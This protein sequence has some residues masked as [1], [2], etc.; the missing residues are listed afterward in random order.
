MNR[1][2]GVIKLFSVISLIVL[3]FIQVPVATAAGSLSALSDTMS[4]ISD[5]TPTSTLSN[6]T[7]KY[8][9]PTGVAAGQSMTVTFPTG[10][11]IG[12]VDYTDID[13]SWGASTGAET[14]L[15]LGA[16][17]ATSTWGAAFVGQILTVT[18]GTGTITAGSKVI[19]EIGTNA[20]AVAT[21]DQQIANHAT[22]ATY[23]LTIAGTFTD[24]GT[25]AIVLVTNDQVAVTASVDPSISFAISANTVALGAMTTGAV[26][27]ASPDITLTIGTNA[28]SGYVVTVQDQGN[29]TTGGLY[30]NAATYNIAS[31]S[32]T[33]TAGAEGYGIQPSSATAT[34]TAPYSGLAGNGVGQLQRTAQSMAT[35]TGPTAANHTVTVKTMAAISG[36]SKAGS[37]ADTLTYI[38]TANF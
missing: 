6:H 31:S 19:I 7:I 37:Y 24:T 11:T 25:I 17:A 32:A 8:T 9:T 23:S 15:T 27:T 33:L 34:L 13:V 10:F 30:N 35:Y 3:G 5:S 16:T 38:A 21:G 22:A 20:T 14:E 36:S 4:R 18:S 29:G 2:D 28:A 1:N 26:A 12:T